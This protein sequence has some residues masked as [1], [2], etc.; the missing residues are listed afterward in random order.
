MAGQYL[1]GTLY[2]AH[3]ISDNFLMNHLAVS[4]LARS[5]DGLALPDPHAL[6]AGAES[7]VSRSA[8]CVTQQYENEVLGPFLAC[9]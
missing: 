5:V 9:L 6:E 7:R 8:R 3:S 4:R 1:L 2:C